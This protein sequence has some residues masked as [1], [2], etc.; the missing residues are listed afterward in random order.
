MQAVSGIPVYDGTMVI[1]TTVLT[2]PGGLAPVVAS[3]GLSGA[4]FDET[5]WSAVGYSVVMPLYLIGSVLWQLLVGVSVRRLLQ[6]GRV[7]RERLASRVVA[8]SSPEV[9]VSAAR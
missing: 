2:L 9:R 8:P 5:T 1:P 7:R 4:F 3:V 6:V